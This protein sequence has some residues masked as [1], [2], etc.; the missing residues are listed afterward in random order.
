[1]VIFRI[2]NINLFHVFIFNCS[3]CLKQLSFDNAVT[4]CKKKGM[5][6]A[7]AESLVDNKCLHMTVAEKGIIFFNLLKHCKKLTLNTL[8]ITELVDVW[9][10]IGMHKRGE[11]NYSKWIN[12]APLNYTEWLPGQ[13]EPFLWDAEQ[14]VITWSN[15]LNFDNQQ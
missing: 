2:E 15:L 8:K 10:W 13:P 5:Q 7:A 12:N 3:K 1:M 11:S 6:L 4:E 9:V 14:C